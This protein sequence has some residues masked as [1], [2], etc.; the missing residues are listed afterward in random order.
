MYAQLAALLLLQKPL[1]TRL[2]LAPC[3]AQLQFNRSLF[4]LSMMK[5]LRLK[6]MYNLIKNRRNCEHIGMQK[7]GRNRANGRFGKFI[8]RTINRRGMESIRGELIISDTLM[9]VSF[10][11]FFPFIMKSIFRYM[12]RMNL[13]ATFNSF[14]FSKMVRHLTPL[15]GRLEFLL[16]KMFKYLNISEIVPI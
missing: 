13:I 6:H 9:N 1:F 4:K 11:F 8:G 10:R 12:S 15:N 3:K 2:F 5:K 7:G 16:K 14:S